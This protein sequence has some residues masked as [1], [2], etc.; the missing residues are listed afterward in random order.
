MSE[1][2]SNTV[3]F[4]KDML[5][6]ILIMGLAALL[7][8]STMTQGFGLVKGPATECPVCQNC[9]GNASGNTT[10]NTAGNASL[11]TMQVPSMLSQSPL[12]GSASSKVTVVEFSDF[13]CP[14]CGMTYG[15][16]WAEAYASQ[17]GPI[18]GTVAKI[19]D[20]YVAA[21]KAALRHY[22]VAFL[23]QESIYASNAAMCANAQGKYWEMHDAIFD[24]QTPEEND[25][26]YSKANLKVLASGI[27]GLDAAAFSSC[28]DGDTYAD[29][30][31]GFT[32]DWQTV[33]AANV[34]RA[35]TPTF[36]ILVDAAKVGK[37]KVKSAAEG[38]GF[39]WGLSS[40]GKT[41]VIV[42]SPEYAKIKLAIDALLA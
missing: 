27:S 1:K 18:I 21:G 12:M 29:T 24:N 40:D 7:V 36:Y 28:V 13:Q 25:G 39:D 5:Y 34:G 15:S 26:K 4:S 37:D 6:G 20:D 35:G 31:D 10:G 23:G 16:P 32:S 17:Y 30:V 41:Y 22:P 33:S 3:T 11:K 19:E 14:F 9:T 38:A 8:I 42:A 2:E